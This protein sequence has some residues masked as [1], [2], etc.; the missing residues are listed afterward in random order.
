MTTIAV[1]AAY[2]VKAEQI[3]CQSLARD[4]ADNLSHFQ[5][6]VQES[7]NAHCGP[8][9]TFQLL[10]TLEK[11]PLVLQQQRPLS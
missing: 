6:M 10:W 7:S 2:F 8:H 3:C 1:I 9:Y 4:E 11:R 5:D